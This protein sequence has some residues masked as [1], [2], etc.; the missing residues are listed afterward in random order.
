MF[1][2]CS[3]DTIG[4]R[5]FGRVAELPRRYVD[6]VLAG[7]PEVHDAVVARHGD[8][9]ELAG[10]ASLAAGSDA[11]AE[12]A[13]LAVLVVDAWQR[14]GLGGAMVDLL[15]GRARER[16]VV[17]VSASVMPGRSRLLGVL[18]RRVEVDRWSPDG[19]TGV[20]RLA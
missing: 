7:R 15:L 6:S 3:P 17:R 8:R 16:G 14:Q 12:I 10:L 18:A 9:G 20:Y 13:E 19:L 5:F 4:W 1:A 2:R 11:G